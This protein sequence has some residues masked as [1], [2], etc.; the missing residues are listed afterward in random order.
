MVV[1]EKK[2]R[3]GKR[4]SRL[5]DANSKTVAYKE[6]SSFDSLCVPSL[7]PLCAMIQ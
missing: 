6:K 4:R 3:G 2:A 5:E 7:S 1:E